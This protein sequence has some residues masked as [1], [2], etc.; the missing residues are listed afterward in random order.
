[1]PND[2]NRFYNG[3]GY[4]VQNVEDWPVYD[5]KKR[6]EYFSKNQHSLQVKSNQYFDNDIAFFA[7]SSFW[8]T[9]DNI[10]NNK[11]QELV[12]SKMDKKNYLKTILNHN[13]L[14]YKIPKSSLITAFYSDYS[15]LYL[16][17][18]KDKDIFYKIQKYFSEFFFVFFLLLMLI[19]CCI[20]FNFKTILFVLVTIITIPS[21]VVGGDGYFE[22]EK[23]LMP[24][25]ILV[26]FY[27]KI[28]FLMNKKHL[29]L[30]KP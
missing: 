4:S 7:G 27:I 21:F 22:F 5:F 12:F 28:V 11:T 8:P 18:N 29:T 13:F 24:F 19:T 3:I 17:Q 25:L 15:M 1:M 23:H 30:E 16:K 2:Y 10:K 26:P 9:G 20:H 6:I 14:I